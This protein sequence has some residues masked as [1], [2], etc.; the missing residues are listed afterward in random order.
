MVNEMVL[1]VVDTQQLIT[2]KEL[3]HFD[4][5]VENVCQLIASARQKG[6]EVIYVCHDDGPES[7]LTAGNPE[8][9]IYDRFKPEEHEKIFIKHVNSS[10]KESGLLEYLTEKEEKDVMIVGLQTDYCIDA[11]IK[12]GF[13]HGFHMIVPSHTN[14]TYSNR[15]MTAEQSYQYHN[16]F[17]WNRRYAQCLPF[18]DALQMIQSQP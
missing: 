6:K 8:F 12:A 4:V 9:E 18:A 2:R 14:S 11:T 1:L 7:E 10:F 15:F 16:E 5:F 17:I 13:E 3:Y